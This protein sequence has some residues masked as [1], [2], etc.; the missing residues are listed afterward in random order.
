[1]TRGPAS[2]AADRRLAEAGVASPEYDAAELLAHVLGT[3]P[4]PASRWSTTS[5]AGPGGG[6]RRPGRRVGPPG[7]RCSTSPAPPAFRYV[8]LAVGPGVFVPR[9]ETELL[10]GWAV[11]HAQAAS[12]PAGARRGRPVHRLR[13]RSRWR[14]RR[15]AG[16]RGARRRARTRRRTTGPSA[17]WPAP[18][19]TCGTATWP[20]PSPTSTARS[21]WWSATRRTSRSRPASPSRREA[22]DHDPA[23]ALWSGDDGLDAMRVLEAVAAR[24]LRPGG[25]VGAEH[26]DVQGESAPAVFAG[27]RPLGRRPRPPRPGRSRRAYVTADWHDDRCDDDR[28]ERRDLRTRF[29]TAD[30]DR[31]RGRRRGRG[32]SRCG[33][34]QLVVLPTDTVYGV[35]ADAFDPD[36]VQR[37]LD[38]KGRGR[39]MPP[40]VLVS[41]ADHPGRARGR[42]AVVGAGLIEELWPGPLTIVCRQQPSLQWDL[43]DT[44]GTV[45]V[46]MPDH[47][48]ALELLG[49]DRSAGGEQRQHDRPA[50]RHGRRRRPRSMLGDVGRRWSSTTGP[51][52]GARAVHDRRRAPAPQGGCCA[53]ARSPSTGSTRSSS[54]SAST[55]TDEG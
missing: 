49:A 20:T 51:T 54:R 3:D 10:A 6:V 43:G 42:R 35:G 23:L 8:E 48:V 55:I 32:R 50:R 12:T 18:G 29:Q 36:A 37:L 52:P 19:S 46:R 2:A 16:R 22:R 45:A 14:R 33:A 30:D 15:G 31:A 44:R 1:M 25:V 13:A 34:A 38:A 17:T 7:S 28:D 40:P 53:S 24:L 47:D 39:D 27:D 9:P 5:H 11:E 26:A 21:T 4:R 41:A